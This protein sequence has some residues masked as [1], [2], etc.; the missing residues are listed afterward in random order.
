MG[1]VRHGPEEGFQFLGTTVKEFARELLKM[2]PSEAR[3]YAEHLGL[4]LDAL[5]DQVLQSRISAVEGSKG[6][7]KVVSKFY[8]VIGLHQFTEAE[9]IAAAKMLA[10]KSTHWPAIWTARTRAPSAGRS[11]RWP[12]SA[13]TTMPPSRRG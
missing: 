8:K 5:M 1:F 9:R 13:S 4:M 3:R 6:V 7:N 10:A 2:E 11:A 12:N